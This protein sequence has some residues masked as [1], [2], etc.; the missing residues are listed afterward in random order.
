MNACGTPN[1]VA[2]ASARPGTGYKEVSRREFTEARFGNFVGIASSKS[3]HA[4]FN[5]LLVELIHRVETDSHQ[6]EVQPIDRDAETDTPPV[7]AVEAAAIRM[8]HSLRDTACNQ[9]FG[10]IVIEFKK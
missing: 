1:L 3:R 7:T 5:R 6:Q 8:S 4:E 9:A 10:F 2:A